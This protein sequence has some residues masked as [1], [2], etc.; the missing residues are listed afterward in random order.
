VEE[1]WSYISFI[2]EA[3]SSGS[4]IKYSKRT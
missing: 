4:G 2:I 3:S 1:C